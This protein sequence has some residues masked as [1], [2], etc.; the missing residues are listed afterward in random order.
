VRIGGSS[1]TRGEAFGIRRNLS[2]GF[3]VHFDLARIANQVRPDPIIAIRSDQTGA[4]AKTMAVMDECGSVSR[5]VK[6]QTPAK[7]IV[8]AAASKAK[9]AET[10]TRRLDLPTALVITIKPSVGGIQFH[11]VS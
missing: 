9:V 3:C 6:T 8:K 2:H 7:N 11:K 1:A 4:K 5:G 10:I